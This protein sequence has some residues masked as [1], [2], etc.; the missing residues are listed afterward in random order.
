MLNDHLQN[1]HESVSQLYLN[2]GFAFIS[3]TYVFVYILKG[4][5]TTASPLL[6]I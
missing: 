6:S 5:I 2:F 3:K 1:L 4:S